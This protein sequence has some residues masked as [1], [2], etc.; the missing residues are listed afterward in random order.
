MT[1][2]GMRRSV[3]GVGDALLREVLLA[4]GQGADIDSYIA[5]RAAECSHHESMAALEMVGGIEGYIAARRAGASHLEVLIC[6]GVGIERSEVVTALEAGVEISDLV[7]AVRAEILAWDYLSARASGASA[8][9]V[10]E[11][12]ECN[13]RRLSDYCL[14]RQLHVAHSEAMGV[15]GAHVRS[16]EYCRRRAL[17]IV[18]K[19]ALASSMADPGGAG[20]RPA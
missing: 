12:W 5:L 7:E 13:R 17:G 19:A 18:H 4:H 8:G 1:D 15:L 9:E 20:M 3:N 2:V 14:M 16:Q 10:L 6:D 11:V